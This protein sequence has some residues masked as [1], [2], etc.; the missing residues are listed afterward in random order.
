MLGLDEVGVNEFVK[1]IFRSK[2]SAL[3]RVPIDLIPWQRIKEF[4]AKYVF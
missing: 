1:D 2:V 3:A 4:A